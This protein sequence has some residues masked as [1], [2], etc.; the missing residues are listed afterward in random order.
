MTSPSNPVA[1]KKA[2]QVSALSGWLTIRTLDLPFKSNG[3]K[4]KVG[5]VVS[6][7]DGKWI[8]SLGEEDKSVKATITKVLKEYNDDQ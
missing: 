5:D 6:L 2:A 1:I 7:S 4:W 8:E 3:D